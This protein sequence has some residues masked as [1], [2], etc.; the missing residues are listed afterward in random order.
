MP[1]PQKRKRRVYSVSGE[2]LYKA[3]EAA[4]AAVQIYNNPQITFKSEIFIVTM[5]IGWTYIMH[6][7]YRRKKIDYRYYEIKSGRKYYDRTKRGA[8][9]YWELERCLNDKESP[10]DKDTANNLRFLI[11]LRHEIE[12]Q[13]TSRIDNFLSARLQACCL[14]F[15]TYMKQLFGKKYGIDKH[16][17]FSLQFSSLSETQVEFLAKANDLPANVQRFIEGFDGSLSEE[18]FNSP[19]FAYRVL[20]V[21]K[22]ANNKGQADQVIQ[23]VRP[24]SPLA[25]GINETYTLIKE[26]EKPKLLP[27]EVVKHM[28]QQGFPRFNM[29][30][31]TE[32]WKAADGKDP[33]KGY[34]VKIAKVWYWYEPW[35]TVVKDHCE[36]NKSLY[37]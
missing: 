3:R 35:L 2:L 32:F 9:K 33:A 11:G 31:H 17:S 16:L 29:N 14:N 4:L 23:F 19:K 1:T 36:K 21:A 12:H 26:T 20:F 22:T 24:D 6:A 10:I 28:R 7:Y 27:S 18:E 13:M 25:Q 15:N 34:G 5:C 30:H 37:C 8:H